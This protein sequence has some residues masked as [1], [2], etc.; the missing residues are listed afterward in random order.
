MSCLT[1]QGGGD[2]VP[3]L[4]V[5]GLETYFSSSGTLQ[6]PMGCEGGPS[7]RQVLSLRPGEQTLREVSDAPE[8]VKFFL[9]RPLAP[10]WCL[11]NW[12]TMIQWVLLAGTNIRA[13]GLDDADGP[14]H[15]GMGL[16]QATNSTTGLQRLKEK[17]LLSAGLL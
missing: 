14:P 12:M 11:D 16:S 9:C 13:D 3:S 2:S 15:C 10:L 1:T 8:S 6:N 5:P 17:D 7:S 4:A